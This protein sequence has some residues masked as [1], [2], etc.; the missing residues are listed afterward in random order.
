M[1]TAGVGAGA[2]AYRQESLHLEAG[3]CLLTEGITA[4]ALHLML[5]VILSTPWIGLMKQ[6]VG[7][8]GLFPFSI[9]PASLA[10]SREVWLSA[11]RLETLM[12]VLLLM[13]MEVG[14]GRG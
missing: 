14:I 3:A 8:A 7:P 4:K 10:P 5:S 9:S 13:V 2:S 6:N 1:C 12:S 11:S